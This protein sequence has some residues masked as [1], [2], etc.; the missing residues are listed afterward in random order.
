[1]DASVDGSVGMVSA[2]GVITTGG[3]IG[4]IGDGVGV[5][6]L[7]QAEFAIKNNIM[8]NELLKYFKFMILF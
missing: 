1:M 6:L 8:K 3:V 7:L 2:A 4:G 5:L